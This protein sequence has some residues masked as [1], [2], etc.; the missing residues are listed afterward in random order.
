MSSSAAAGHNDIYLKTVNNPDY[1]SIQPDREYSRGHDEYIRPPDILFGDQRKEIECT[2]KAFDEEEHHATIQEQQETEREDAQYVTVDENPVDERRTKTI[3]LNDPSELS[4]N[5]NKKQQEESSSRKQRLK[6]DRSKT[7][8]RKFPGELK[9]EKSR[10]RRY[11]NTTEEEDMNQ[12]QQQKQKQQPLLQT[13]G[14]RIL[15]SEE[16]SAPAPPPPLPPTGMKRQSAT[17][18]PPSLTP[19]PPGPSQYQLERERQL[20]QEQKL[21]HQIRLNTANMEVENHAQRKQLKAVI[22][23]ALTGAFSFSTED[24]QLLKNHKESL[25]E[26]L[27]SP[28]G[29]SLIGKL[30]LPADQ[31]KFQ[32]RARQ[33]Q[34]DL[35][36]AVIQH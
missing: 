8:D 36:G 27:L 18:R 6:L 28:Q 13:S 12:Q 17:G 5:D 11:K 25:R 2:I 33:E 21:A 20:Q 19:P 15:K 23:Q 9:K 10:L 29:T 24:S 32:A 14:A 26:S 16:D 34:Q 22:I 4:E 1:T 30:F 3:E 31:S 7:N 35:F